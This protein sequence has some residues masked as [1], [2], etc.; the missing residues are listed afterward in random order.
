MNK[1]EFI[2]DQYAGFS[3]EH[4]IGGGI[5]NYIPYLRR[6]KLRQFWT[7]KGVIGSLS[8]A[9]QQ[10]NLNKGYDFHTLQGNPYIELGTGIDNI[11][12][13]F[14]IDFVWRVTPKPQP[15]EDKGRYFG[16]FGSV[17]FQF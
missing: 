13:L 10:L 1:Y 2:S 17:H 6:A 15:N 7:A 3:I 5:F 14:R 11:L 12:E 4:N 8:D 9:N 16:I